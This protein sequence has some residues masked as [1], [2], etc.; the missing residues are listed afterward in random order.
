MIV[1]YLKHGYRVSEVRSHEYCRAW[2]HSKLSTFHK[3]HIFFW[4]LFVDLISGK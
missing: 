1:Q 4:R 3:A 2:G